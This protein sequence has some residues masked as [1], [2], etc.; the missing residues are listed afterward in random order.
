MRGRQYGEVRCK[1]DLDFSPD[2][3]E[4]KLVE[5]KETDDIAP[6]QRNLKFLMSDNR[7][8]KARQKWYTMTS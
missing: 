5:I 6:L 2:S 3:G 1:G 8:A 4:A 7:D